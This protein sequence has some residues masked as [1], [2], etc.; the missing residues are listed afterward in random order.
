VSVFAPDGTPSR[1]LTGLNNPRA[2]AFDAQGNLYVANAGSSRDPGTTVSVFDSHGH[3]TATLT[4]LDGPSA[5]AFD[6]RGDLYVANFNNGTVSEFTPNSTTPKATLTGLDDPNALA[7]DARGNLFVSNLGG[8]TVSVFGPDGSPQAPLTGL[9]APS[10]LAFDT[11]GNLYVTNFGRTNTGITVSVFAPGGTTPTATLS[12]LNDPTALAFDT[13]GNLYVA[14]GGNNT[15]SRFA[16]ALQPTAGGVV[17]RTARPD[18]PIHVGATSSPGVNLSNAELARIFTTAAGTITFGDPSQTGNITFAD[19]T[20]ATTPGA[21]DIA[22]QAP[23]G[24]G[25]II[26]DSTAGTA[27]AAGSGNVRLSA[28]SGGIVAVGD[29]SAPSIASSGQVSLD[30][31]GGIGTAADPVGF[32]ALATP[33]ALTVGTTR[34]PGRGVYLSGQGTL[35]LGDVHTAN[36]AP[37]AVTAGGLTVAGTLSA[38]DT[39]L[40]AVAV[41]VNQGARVTAGAGNT[42]AVRADTLD[43]LGTLS[44]RDISLSDLALTVDAGASVTAGDTLAVRADTLDLL[45]TLSAGRSGLVS[46]TP[47]SVTR[48]I[49]LGGSG[50]STDLV[51]TD[52]ALSRVTAGTLRIGDASTYLGDITVT[53][54]VTRHAGHDTLSLR[55]QRGSINATAGATLSVAK[56]ALQAGSGVGTTG[57][58]AI[59]AADLAFASLSGPIQLSDAKRVYHRRRRTD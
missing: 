12:R 49:D 26:L 14:N 11:R 43:L 25:T 10:A 39:S 24:S 7:F 9:D 33:T 16:Y 8:D 51:L 13:S 17:V 31:T 47:F 30:T 59:D 45:G 18:L 38:G 23:A 50:P 34:V 57:R 48:D 22:L 19:A 41:T 44:A 28:G 1:T 21:N 56:L 42:L 52:S 29:H 58:M 55:T 37:L 35:T 27:L 54:D 53:G 2:L 4:G 36:L 32:Q 5:L 3:L 46:L 40:S 20:P 6:A 15:V